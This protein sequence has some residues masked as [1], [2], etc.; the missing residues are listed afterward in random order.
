MLDMKLCMR[1]PSDHTWKDPRKKNYLIK[2]QAKH[3]FL[4]ISFVSHSI[5]HDGSLT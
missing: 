4:Q 5:V 3:N 1:N 2:T